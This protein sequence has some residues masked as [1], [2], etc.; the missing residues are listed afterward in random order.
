VYLSNG[1]YLPLPPVW[2]PDLLKT[3]PE[4]FFFDNM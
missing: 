1:D 3:D 2:P 4:F